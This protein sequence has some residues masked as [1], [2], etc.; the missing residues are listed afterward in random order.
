MTTWIAERRL[1]FAIKGDS[2]RR[3][4][5]IRIGQPYL[6][7]K[8]TVNFE[9]HDGAAGCLV[10]FV[11]LDDSGPHETYGV[12]SLQALQLAANIEPVLKALSSKYDFFFS[13]GESY[14]EAGENG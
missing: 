7:E 8:G 12:D 2:K 4:L 10:E 3:A 14:F 5:V 1:L 13:D 11:G 9:F 6:L